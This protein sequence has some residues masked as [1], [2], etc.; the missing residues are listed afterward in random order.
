M[1]TLYFTIGMKHILL[2]LTLLLVVFSITSCAKKIM[3]QT[4]S[5]I[6]AARG[7]VA[8]KKDKNNNYQVQMTLS[9][10]A[11]PE[12]LSPAK[13]TYVVWV[14]SEENEIPVNLGQIIGTSKLKVKFETI[15]S[16]KPKKIFITAENDASTQYPGNMVVLQTDDL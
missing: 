15:T 11:E 13:N 5:V 6:P 2:T 16:S 4:S 14:V 9:Y 7:Q 10:L 3:F 12:R 1:K 8:L